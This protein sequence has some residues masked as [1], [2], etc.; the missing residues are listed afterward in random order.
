MPADPAA[1]Q[2]HDQRPPGN[3]STQQNRKRKFLLTDQSILDGH[4]GFPIVL[5]QLAEESTTI[6]IRTFGSFAFLTIKG[7]SDQAP[8]L[9]FEYPIPLE[10]ALAMLDSLCTP[11]PIRKTR[12]L[13]PHGQLAVEVDVFEDRLAGLVIAEVEDA[14]DPSN[15]PP[16][17]GAE[18]TDN[19]RFDPSALAHVETPPTSGHSTWIP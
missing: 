5:G 15:L 11:R 12:Y 19:P 7:A 2:P 17:L 13:I 6:S 18:I 16:W 14:A 1:S 3:V 8:S 10:D 4:R 9:G